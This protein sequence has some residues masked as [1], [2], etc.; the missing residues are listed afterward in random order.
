SKGLVSDVGN[1]LHGIST[2]S[3]KTAN[4]PFYSG[5]KSRNH[6]RSRVY[7]LLTLKKERKKAL[8]KKE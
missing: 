6:V 2:A 7:A 4:T 5:A 8:K 1:K 3:Q